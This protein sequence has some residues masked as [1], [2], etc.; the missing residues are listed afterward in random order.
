MRKK[1]QTSII[2]TTIISLM[3]SLL[4]FYALIYSLLLHSR[5]FPLPLKIITPQLRIPICPLDHFHLLLQV[6]FPN[7]RSMPSQ[8]QRACIQFPLV[9]LL[10]PGNHLP[11]QL[12]PHLCL[13]PQYPLFFLHL[14]R[15]NL[16]HHRHHHF[17]HLLLKKSVL[18]PL[19]QRSIHPQ[20][21][22]LRF[23][24]IHCL[25]IR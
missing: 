20:C 18:P 16:R 7:R 13:L 12:L 3:H 22:F 4:P 21:H 23:L 17:H 10:F 6:L 11:D 19:L 25:P 8:Y 24:L 14:P 5:L 15:F 1:D 2:P 9:L